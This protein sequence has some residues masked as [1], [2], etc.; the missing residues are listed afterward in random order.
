MHFAASSPRHGSNSFGSVYT[1]AIGELI[2]DDDF[3]AANG[4]V[5]MGVCLEQ[6][7]S[8]AQAVGEAIHTVRIAPGTNMRP[9]Y[10]IC[11]ELIR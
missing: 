3:C 5:G 7:L 4:G 10:H 1:Y 9:F 8:K 2:V 6:A 11:D